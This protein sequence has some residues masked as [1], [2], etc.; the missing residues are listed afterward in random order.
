MHLPHNCKKKLNVNN[1][2]TT[3]GVA[4]LKGR[5]RAIRY[6]LFLHGVKYAKPILF[7]GYLTILVQKKYFHYYR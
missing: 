3:L 5:R 1:V 4:P 6:N 2:N 7:S